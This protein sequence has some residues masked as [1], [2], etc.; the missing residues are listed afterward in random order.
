MAR[1]DDGQAGAA[2][3]ADI[4]KSCVGT[5]TG[6]AEHKVRLGEPFVAGETSGVILGSWA[7]GPNPRMAPARGP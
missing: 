3:V 7:V 5:L 1:E 6:L 4:A 2:V